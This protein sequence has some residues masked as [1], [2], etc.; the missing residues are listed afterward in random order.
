MIVEAFQC[1]KCGQRY[2]I[3]PYYPKAAPHGPNKDC[4]GELGWTKV[5]ERIGE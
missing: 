5:K 1:N 3:M 4:W 2:P